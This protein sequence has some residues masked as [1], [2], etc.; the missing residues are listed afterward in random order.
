LQVL[1]ILKVPEKCE[2]TLA[3]YL[4]SATQTD[5]IFSEGFFAVYVYTFT[6]FVNS[7]VNKTT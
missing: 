1:F 7:I 2:L 5:I 4:L 6:F 3:P